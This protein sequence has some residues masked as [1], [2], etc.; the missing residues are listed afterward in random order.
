MKAPERSRSIIF[1]TRIYKLCY[2]LY[3]VYV[4]GCARGTSCVDTAFITLNYTEL[5]VYST[6]FPL[7][8]LPYNLSERPIQPAFD[9]FPF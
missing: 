8:N 7:K 9:A 4:V 5:S 1:V 3:S 2:A 6:R